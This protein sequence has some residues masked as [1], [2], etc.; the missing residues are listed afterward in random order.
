MIAVIEA[1][2]RKPYKGEKPKTSIM[3]FYVTGYSDA[4]RT[5]KAMRKITKSKLK[6]VEIRES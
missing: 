1:T 2:E 3:K 6:L 4:Q 5:L